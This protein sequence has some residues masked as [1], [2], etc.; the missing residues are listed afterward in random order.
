MNTQK[1]GEQIA[2]LRKA[3]GLT[4]N[5]LGERLGVTFQSV[6]KWERG[7]TLPDTAILVDL[8]DVL[9]TTVDFI[10]TGGERR[11][12]Y[13]GKASVGDMMDGLRRL[14]DMGRLLGK[15]NLIYRCAIRG[16]DE[17][18]NTDIEEAFADEYIF[19]CFAAEAVIQS[20]AAGAY[21]DPTDVKLHFKQEHFRKIVL[22][23]CEKHGI[24]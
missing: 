4:Q 23:F 18:M 2:A 3:K 17:G 14:E 7:E 1:V 24:K 22:D 20:L 10:L 19:E 16:I 12:Q 13:R 21:V 15:E 6:S 9:E 11:L 8:A 5:D